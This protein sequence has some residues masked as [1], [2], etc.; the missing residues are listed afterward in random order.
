MLI[1]GGGM[2]V[3]SVH[4]NPKDEHPYENATFIPEGFN[5]FAFIFGGI[6]AFYHR[7]VAVGIGFF[8]VWL[9]MIYLLNELHF[10]KESIALMDIGIRLMF[11]LSA[12]D[13][14]RKTLARQ[15][16]VNSDIIVANSPLEAM[17]RYLT[18]HLGDALEATS[19]AT[20]P[21]TAT[22][23]MTGEIAETTPVS[24]SVS[25]APTAKSSG[26]VWRRKG[27]G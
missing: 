10:S 26:M 6:W 21:A 23:D 17:H 7:M 13:L 20:M 9:G 5:L 27:K 18:R 1:P 11:A 19:P 12:N 22:A 16:H 4:L 2:K 25:S 14:W 15:G 8:V 24:A 3:Y